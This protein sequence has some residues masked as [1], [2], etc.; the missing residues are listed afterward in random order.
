[1][2]ALG[3]EPIVSHYWATE[4]FQREL[5]DKFDRY[6]LIN[7]QPSARPQRCPASRQFRQVNDMCD[8]LGAKPPGVLRKRDNSA[9]EHQRANGPYQ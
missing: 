3:C 6:C 2:P 7:G 1:M 5:A 4:T 9:R 8:F